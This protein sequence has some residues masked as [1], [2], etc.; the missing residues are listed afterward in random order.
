MKKVAVFLLIVALGVAGFFYFTR[1]VEQPVATIETERILVSSRNA[2]VYRVSPEGTTVS[3]SV[4]EMLAG[5][6]FTAVGTT[7]QVSGEIAIIREPQLAPEIKVATLKID[8]RTFVTDDPQRDGAVNRFIL[9]TETPG[10]EYIVFVPTTVQQPEVIEAEKEFT[11]TVTGDMTISGITKPTTLSVV[12][13]ES[14]G[15]LSGILTTQ[16]KRSDYNLVI[17]NIPFV[18]NVNDVI[19]VTATFVAEEV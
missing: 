3:F 7:N 13:T 14:N 8:A 10:N 5:K 18:A 12:A 9:K 2:T 19:P 6:P 1:P 16:I 17:P 11:F 15:T 4:D